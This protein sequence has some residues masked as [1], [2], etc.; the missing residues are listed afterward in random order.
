M[1]LHEGAEEGRIRGGCLI[2]TAR[3]QAQVV[4]SEIRY[5]QKIG[6]E[7]RRKEERWKRVAGLPVLFKDTLPRMDVL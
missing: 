7:I 4:R 6:A 3:N 2:V 5:D 1:E